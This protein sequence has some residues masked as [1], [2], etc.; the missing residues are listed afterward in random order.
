MPEPG[1]PARDRTNPSI[2]DALAADPTLQLDRRAIEL[3]AHDQGRWTRR[4]LLLPASI[5]SRVLVA[6]ICLLKRLLPF[7]FSAHAAMDRLCLWFLRRFVSPEA[8][9]LLVRHF[10]VETNLLNVIAANVGPDDIPRVE[11]LPTSL[12]ELG[13]GAV[14]EH[15]LNVYNLVLDLGERSRHRRRARLPPVPAPGHRDGPV[16]HEHSVRVVPDGRRVPARGPLPP[17]RRDLAGLPGRPHRRHDLPHLAAGGLHHPAPHRPRRPQGGVRPRR[18]LRVRPRSPAR[19]AQQVRKARTS[20]QGSILT[21]GAIRDVQTLT[22]IQ[23]TPPSEQARTLGPFWGRGG[24]IQS[25]STARM[26]VEAPA[27]PA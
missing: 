9:E 8:V 14:I 26:M 3:L 25:G 18:H 12:A 13:N 19:T 7:Q 23:T 10:I 6:L 21:A 11:L 15:D 20:N 17:A 4:Y 16:L 27:P 5:A 2:W 24:K 22:S 1:H